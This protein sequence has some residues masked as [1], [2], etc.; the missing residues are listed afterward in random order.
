MLLLFASALNLSIF[1]LRFDFDPR[2]K[3]VLFRSPQSP[4]RVHCVSL[5]RK[6]CNP[7]GTLETGSYRQDCG[8]WVPEV[9]PPVMMA[10][11]QLWS[12]GRGLIPDFC[13]AWFR[14]E[15]TNKWRYCI[16]QRSER[17]FRMIQTSCFCGGKMQ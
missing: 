7:L 12:L 8:L 3:H 15:N 11:N 13:L 17:G 16:L 10:E 1:K 9:R 5:S 2:P 4:L 6:Y 14:P